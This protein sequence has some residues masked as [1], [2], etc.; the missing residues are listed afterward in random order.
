MIRSALCPELL[1]PA[2]DYEKLRMAVAY[3][4]DA[5]YLA[6]NE[7][8]MRTAAGN[9]EPDQ[10]REAIRYCHDHSVK[11]YVTVNTI[12]RSNELSRIA[13]F[14]ELL[15]EYGADAAIV[16]DPG[17]FRI[18]QKHAPKLELHI[19]TQAGI[20]NYAS[21]EMWYEMG[22]KRIILARELSL[23]DIA[24]IR[25]NTPK[26]LQIECFV[27]G[28]MCVSFSGRC[29]L[30]EYLTGRDA[31]RGNCAQP[32][33]WKYHLREE[34]REGAYYEIEEAKEGT[35]ILNA[36]DLCAIRFLNQL[37]EAGVH[38]L[39]IEGRAKSAYYAAATTFAYRGALDDLL[40]GKPFDERWYDEACKVS[41]R[42]YCDGFFFDHPDRPMQH[43]SDSSYIREWDIC[44]VVEAC[45]EEGNALIRHK[46]RFRVG[47]PLELLMPRKDP[48]PVTLSAIQTE[49]YEDVREALHPHALYRCTLPV[50]APPLS[51]L[52]KCT[53]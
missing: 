11:A 36:K 7:F 8:G 27:H 43:Y 30:S 37:L 13:P 17:V 39:K 31:N 41:H 20:T 22:A 51:I 19:S 50:P 24:E 14:A 21:A 33:R 42:P 45:G 35:Y 46:N 32:C 44:A 15:A 23:A 48:I 40:S 1:A 25:A 29:L 6:G 16:S 34:K 53:K 2:G 10:L 3:G 38:S 49:E 4:A 12:P 18:L 26:D 5:V 52:R 47:E 9:F 28:A